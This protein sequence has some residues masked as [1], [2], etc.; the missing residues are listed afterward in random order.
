MKKIDPRNVTA[1]LH[2]RAR[3]NPPSTLPASAISNSFPGLEFDFRNLWR[4]IFVGLV[5]MENSNYVLE[6]EDPAYEGL[7]GHR[8]LRIDGKDMVVT[9][10]GPQMPG[11]DPSP[12]TTG[13]NPGAS[14]PM[15]WSNVIARVLQYQGQEV[16]CDF[17]PAPSDNNAPVPG[18][19]TPVKRVR[20]RLRHV[21]EQGSALIARELLQPGELTQGL[22]SPWQNDYRECACYYWAASR[23]DYVNV[24]PT[25]EGLSAGDNWLS[26]KRTGEYIPDDRKDS[27]LVTYDDLFKEWQ[28]L[29]RFQIKGRDADASEPVAHA[30]HAHEKQG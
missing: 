7:K 9:V 27:R 15:E 21:F 1:Q 26:K 29:L 17:T 28:A 4:R 24:Q 25:P 11:A 20:L 19:D 16:D 2:H 8:L 12:L 13:T 18:K 6:V 10:Q 23:P 3:G 30:D 14:A 5:M 22:C